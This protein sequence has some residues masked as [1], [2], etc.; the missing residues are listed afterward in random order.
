M[1]DRNLLSNRSVWIVG[2]ETTDRLIERDLSPLDQL[3]DR[4]SCD[5]FRG[6]SERKSRIY[7]IRNSP[8][9]I[10]HAVRESEEQFAVLRDGRDTGEIAVFQRPI[11]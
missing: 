3:H 9:A 2:K 7:G 10:L 8:F 4:D 5:H 11:E 1:P 6:R